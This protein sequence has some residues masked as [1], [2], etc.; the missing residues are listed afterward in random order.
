MLIVLGGLPGVG[1]TSIARELAREIAAV[2][3]RI[4]SIEEAIRASGVTIMPLDD[5]GYRAA[6]AVAVDN[7]L[8]GHIVIADSVNPLPV[9]RAA[10]LGVAKHA[11]VP[12]V[13]VEIRC[14]NEAEHRRRVEDRL[15]VEQTGPTWLDV[16]GRDYR[17]WPS[18]NYV[19]D[20]AARTPAE[21]AQELRAALG[22]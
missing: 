2:H 7:L 18:A 10:W 20:T 12:V 8:L 3:V 13:E 9:T 14:S 4:D 16:V 11:Q 19:I 6:Y 21:A 15:R 17:A 22:S 1:K 5:A